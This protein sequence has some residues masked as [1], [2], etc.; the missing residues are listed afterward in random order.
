MRL[1][2]HSYREIQRT[3]NVS[4]GTLSVWL[5]DL[6]LSPEHEAELRKRNAAAAQKRATTRRA[7]TVL[8]DR[9][10][11]TKA[12]GQIPP[13]DRAQLFV[14]GVVAYWAEGT[15]NKPWRRGERVIF[16]NS[17]PGLVALFL[18]WLDLLGV[19]RERLSFRVQIHERA[20]VAAA[21]NG[22]PWSEFLP[23]DSDRRP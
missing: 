16:V 22:L 10:I 6:P 13:L 23:I 8:R 19:D 17:D 3:L 15:K 11:V 1:E 21:L 7:L 20:D 5:R 14:A 4:R 18:R 12:A 9:R 2:G